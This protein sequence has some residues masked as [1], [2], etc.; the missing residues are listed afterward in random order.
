MSVKGRDTIAMYYYYLSIIITIIFLSLCLML[1][2]WC[3]WT[4]ENHPG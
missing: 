4:G 1:C 3:A 2:E